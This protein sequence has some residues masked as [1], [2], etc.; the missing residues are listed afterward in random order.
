MG[1]VVIGAN[2]AGLSAAARA[3]R[4]DRSLE[5]TVLEKGGI[6][7]YASCGLPYYL[8]SR[9]RSLDELTRYT[10]EYFERERGITVR[11][12]TEVASIRHPRR[13]LS[14][15]TGE[16]V[17]Y[18]RLIIAT[19]ARADRGGIRGADQPHVFTLQTFDDAERLKQDL[20]VRQPRRAVVIG[21]GYIGL[22]VADALRANGLRVTILEADESI[23]G[24]RDATLLKTLLARF[25]RFG[26]EYLP[27]Q[28]VRAIEGDSVNGVPADL[29]VIAAGVRPNI[30]LAEEAGIEV[31][32]T[33][34]IRV[35]EQLE[36]NLHDVFAAGDC[37]ETLHR[38]TGR[39]AYIP[40]GTTANKM[41]RI[42]GANAAGR[43]ERFAGVMG[44]S[45]VQVCGLGVGMTGLSASQARKEGFD[46]V[47]T[48]VDALERPRYF[49]GVQTVV[50]LVAERR[51]GRLL[52]GTVIGEK[53]V[54][55]R[56]NVLATALEARLTVDDMGNLD[57]AYAPPFA[58]VWDPILIA[59]QQLRKLI[60]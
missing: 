29:V 12:N 16:R 50:E 10:P 26:I 53:G 58:T 14:L 48:A 54:G 2:A 41:G 49:W 17:T 5:I 25:K 1:L 35:S 24:R 39:P 51:S 6:I 15:V 3:R 42:A 33:G 4:I 55:G 57:L 8:E 28:P 18:D 46:A 19:G 20:K 47:A 30:E 7:S 59:V 11:T 32:R 38:I 56:T 22:E 44:T 21:A 9:V 43:R 13:E 37:A 27:N 60:D 36:T 31:G 34:A 52:G 45:I 40:L 23:L